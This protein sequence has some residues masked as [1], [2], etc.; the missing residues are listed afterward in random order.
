MWRSILN[1][2]NFPKKKITWE[3]LATVIGYFGSVDAFVN[4]ICKIFKIQPV[5]ICFIILSAI[6]L[7]LI[8]L[9]GI[10]IPYNGYQW[11]KVRRAIFS[12]GMIPIFEWWEKK[13]GIPICIKISGEYRGR[14]KNKIFQIK[15]GEKFSTIS[16]I[17]ISISDPMD[18]KKDIHEKMKPYTW[19]NLPKPIRKLVWFN[20][21]GFWWV[22]IHIICQIWR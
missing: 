10:V 15:F 4:W 6:Y 7:I 8:V 2:T 9:I 12:L 14:T 22:P 13:F 18:S 17:C 16:F 21:T 19:K 5:G 1:K 11:W 20:R 3:V